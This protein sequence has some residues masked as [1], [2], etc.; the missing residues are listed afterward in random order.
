MDWP[1]AHEDLPER[2]QMEAL[3]QIARSRVP[4]SI[5]HWSGPTRLEEE[6]IIPNPAVAR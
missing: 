5:F 2:S 6:A 1:Y 3:A 4:G